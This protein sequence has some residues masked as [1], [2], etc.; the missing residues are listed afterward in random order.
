MIV[1][2]LTGDISWGRVSVQS[3]PITQACELDRALAMT[4][5]PDVVSIGRFDPYPEG[6]PPH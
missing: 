4:A 3:R 6:F 5:R 1:P 2:L